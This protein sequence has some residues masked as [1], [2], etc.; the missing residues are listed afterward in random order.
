MKYMIELYRINDRAYLG[1]C[2]VGRIADEA[3][4][5]IIEVGIAN[6]EIKKA[7][8]L[9]FKTEKGQGKSTFNLSQPLLADSNSA[10]AYDKLIKL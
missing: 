2:P 1:S 3:L 5:H 8:I 4:R 9:K 10:D 6:G 7:D